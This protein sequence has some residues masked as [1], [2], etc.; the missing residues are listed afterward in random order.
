M[1]HYI[2]RWKGTKVEHR[3]GDFNTQ[4]HVG[5][6]GGW[7]MQTAHKFSMAIADAA[8]ENDNGHFAAQWE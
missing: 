7:L 2:E 1:I 8:Q 4:L 6:R 5:Q 3:G